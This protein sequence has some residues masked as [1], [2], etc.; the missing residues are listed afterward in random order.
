[1]DGDMLAFHRR[2]GMTIIPYSSQAH[3]FFSKLDEGVSI[4]EKDMLVYDN[5][6]NQRRLEQIQA[7]TEKYGAMVNDIVLAY[8]VSQPFTTI[9]IIGPRLPEQLD[10]S[11]EALDFKLTAEELSALE[12]A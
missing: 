6:L 11:I 3:G 1:M 4:S 10:A 7:L 9:P 8:L 12:N 5:P 2:T